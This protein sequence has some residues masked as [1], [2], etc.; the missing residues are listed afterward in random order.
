MSEDAEQLAKPEEGTKINIE[1]SRLFAHWMGTEG[2]LLA[3]ACPKNKGLAFV[4]RDTA[5][6]PIFGL[7]DYP[8]ATCLAA[9]PDGNL[10]LA[11]KNS[12]WKIENGKRTG[13][14]QADEKDVYLPRLRIVTGDLGI[15]DMAVD[16]RGSLLV[17]SRN[18]CMV[19]RAT[20]EASLEP[21]WRPPFLAAGESG[22]GC[23]LS[24][25]GLYDA[26]RHCVTLHSR[27]P[28]P[29][30]DKSADLESGVVMAIQD[31]GI[32][33]E[34]LGLPRAPRWTPSGLCLLNTATAEFGRVD[35]DTKRFVPVCQCPA[36]PTG[37][38]IHGAWAV[39]SVSSE[40]PVDLQSLPARE[41]F[42]RHG[43][44]PFAGVLC[45]DLRS[46]DIAHNFR[47]DDEIKQVEG[48]AVLAGVTAAAALGPENEKIDTIVV[49]KRPAAAQQ[50]QAA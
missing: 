31:G 6:K 42:A 25:L 14:F 19:G 10:W 12:I 8:G 50:T 39:I 9:A 11:Q 17:A 24:G 20:I 13:G 3:L 15:G 48:V 23:G 41:R 1:C 32:L 22:V 18:L 5:N 21:V 43:M 49:L 47:F 37:M 35:P 4:G 7:F 29:D 45:V 16:G 26:P 44:E 33:C 34:G 28:R 27:D 38:V 46:G 36:Y 30:R 40:P 2:A